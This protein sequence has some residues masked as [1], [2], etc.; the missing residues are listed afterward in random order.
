MYEVIL[1]AEAE[2]IYASADRALAKKIARCFEQLEQNPYFHP[3]IKS[4]KGQDL[5]K[6][7]VTASLRATATY[8]SYRTR[9]ANAK[10]LR[11]LPYTSFRSQ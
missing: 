8:M 11:L 5:R 4:L 7:N 1:S 10:I 2:D 9:S 3:N 6:S